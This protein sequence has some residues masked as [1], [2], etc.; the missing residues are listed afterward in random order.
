MSEA[1]YQI[2]VTWNRETFFGIINGIFIDG[3]FRVPFFLHWLV[4]PLTL[5]LYSFCH[6]QWKRFFWVCEHFA[7]T[8]T[9]MKCIFYGLKE[10]EKKIA[11]HKVFH[12]QLLSTAWSLIS[13]Y[14]F[15]WYVYRGILQ[16]DKHEKIFT[17]C[18]LRYIS[19]NVATVIIND[20]STTLFTF[21][22]F[23]YFFNPNDTGLIIYKSKTFHWS[24]MEADMIELPWCPDCTQSIN[25]CV[26]IIPIE[27]SSD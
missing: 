13:W 8:C 23:F 5:L 21:I 27:C 19:E 6:F 25:A 16:A 2:V 14:N 18:L 3:F 15:M 24:C 1:P 7:L 22:E 10:R 20:A 4:L 9:G 26:A 11:K 12:A 17:A